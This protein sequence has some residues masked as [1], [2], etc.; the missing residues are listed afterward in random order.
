MVE[1]LGDHKGHSFGH[2][3]V[4]LTQ[5]DV[6]SHDFEG[7]SADGYLVVKVVVALHGVVEIVKHTDHLNGA[8]HL[9]PHHVDVVVLHRSHEVLHQFGS[10]SDVLLVK[11]VDE[12]LAQFCGRTGWVTLDDAAFDCLELP[13]LIDVDDFLFYHL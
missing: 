9:H 3:T 13:V 10:G 12:H 7:S 2:E 6:V 1:L 4:N 11:S 5:P 8:V